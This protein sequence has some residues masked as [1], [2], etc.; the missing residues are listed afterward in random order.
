MTR[1]LPLSSMMMRKN[2]GLF[3]GL[4]MISKVSKEE[5]VHQDYRIDML[6]V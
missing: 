3:I 1:A 2:Y 4:I 6:L 5:S